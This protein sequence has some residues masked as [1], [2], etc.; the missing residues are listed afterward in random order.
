MPNLDQLSQEDKDKIIECYTTMAAEDD[1]KYSALQC[2]AYNE[3]NIPTEEVRLAV[4]VLIEHYS[5]QGEEVLNQ[6]LSYDDGEFGEHI[7]HIAMKDPDVFSDCCAVLQNVGLLDKILLKPDKDRDTVM[8]QM[9]EYGRLASFLVLVKNQNWADQVESAMEETNK[10]GETVLDLLENF[11]GTQTIQALRKD[12][13]CY[14]AEHFERA[15]GMI[16]EMNDAIVENFPSL[17]RNCGPS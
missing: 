13:E 10:F 8:V 1:T 3:K 6:A 2:A 16:A 7:L 9:V 15:K 12:N 4:Q 17:R 11:E 14:E 5:K